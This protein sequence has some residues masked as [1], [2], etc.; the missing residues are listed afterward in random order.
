MYAR[1]YEKL[2][3]CRV[4]FSTED[5]EGLHPLS[6][7]PHLVHPPPFFF[8]LHE[9]TDSAISI[10]GYMHKDVDV[11]L[12]SLH[13]QGNIQNIYADSLQYQLTNQA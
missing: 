1:V 3:S 13:F 5:E 9:A 10:S 8:P 11:F 4:L 2:F 12:T 7:S 6:L